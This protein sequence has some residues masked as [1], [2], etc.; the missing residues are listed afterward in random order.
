MQLRT[1]SGVTGF[2]ASSRPPTD[3]S[4]DDP[5]EIKT[6]YL[7]LFIPLKTAQTIRTGIREAVRE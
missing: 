2:M 1:P 6:R 4:E 3:P 5:E 7:E